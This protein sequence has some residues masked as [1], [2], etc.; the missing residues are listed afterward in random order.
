MSLTICDKSEADEVIMKHHYSKKA[1]KNSFLS[2]RV[3]HK[4]FT[5]SGYIQ[6]GYGIRPAMKSKIHPKIKKGNFAEFD[7]M[8]LP[9]IFP[10]FSE[11]KTISLLL[12]FLKQTRKNIAFLI[13]Y[14]DGSVGNTGTIYKASNAFEIGSTPC[15]FY[16]LSTGE[17][18]HPV[19]MYH[20]HGTR[21]K[22]ALERIY[23]DG[24]RHIKGE[25]RQYRFLYILNK[26]L[27]REFYNKPASLTTITESEKNKLTG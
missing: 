7:R 2:F 11:T 20:R 4:N 24:I 16:V 23:P 17:R 5:E 26:K 3:N 22:A 19:S 10:K 6:L 8:W 9:D 14:A 1:A 15:D 27:R 18:V 12:S 13:T 25:Y 21:A